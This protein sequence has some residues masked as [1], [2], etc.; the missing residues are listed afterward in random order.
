MTGGALSEMLVASIAVGLAL[1]GLLVLGRRPRMVLIV[2]LAT[3]CLVPIWMTVSI[4]PLTLEPQSVVALGC[5]T[6][7]VPLGTKVRDEFTLADSL[8]V[9]LVVSGLLGVV[10][11]AWSLES[12]FRLLVSWSVAYLLGRLLWRRLDLVV[13]YR[14]IAVAFTVVALLALVEAATGVNAFIHLPGSTGLRTAWASIQVRG[15]V[16]RAEGSFGHSIALGGCLAMAVP[17]TLA[18]RLRAWLTIGAVTLMAGATV[19]TFSRIGMVTLALG[20]VL[21]LVF[22]PTGLTT[23]LRVILAGAVAVGAA[24]V[25]PFVAG[26]FGAAGEEAT[27]SA[28]YRGDLISLFGTAQWIGLASSS[29]RSPNGEVYFGTFRSIDNALLLLALNSGLLA[30]LCVVLALGLAAGAVFSRRA[31]APTIALV[32][33]IPAFATV[34]LITQFG[35]WVWFLAGLAVASQVA[36]AAPRRSTPPAVPAPSGGSGPLPVGSPAPAAEG[37]LTDSVRGH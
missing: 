25:L 8:M 33:Q 34:A 37:L 11:G 26:V 22:L 13:V 3:M 14:G 2:W 36:A 6:G 15:G 18:A 27:A 10:V 1:A 32:A 17:I 29:Y 31:T 7:L 28:A 19:A 5:L 35:T 23:R 4:G 21:T 9:G 12:V 24:A 16:S 20:L 30:L